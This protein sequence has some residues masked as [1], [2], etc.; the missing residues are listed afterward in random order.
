MNK[1]SVISRIRSGKPTIGSWLTIGHSAVAE[2]LAQAG[3]DW[4]GID[5]EHTTVDWSDMQSMMQAMDACGV[6]PLVRVTSNNPDSIKRAMDAGAAGVIVP[7]VNSTEDARR[8]VASVKYPPL[9]KR[10]VGLARANDYG[11]AFDQYKKEN[12]KNSLVIIQIEHVD[13]LDEI[14]E[15]FSVPGVDAYMVGPYDLSGS[16]GHP[17]EFSHPLMKKA[18]T[19]IRQAGKKMKVPAGFHIVHPDPKAVS[20]RLREGFSFIAYGV[21]M[22]FLATSARDGLKQIKKSVK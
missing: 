18:L 13:A 2:I 22:I 6:V 9:G 21:D 10:G 19:Q 3:F 20:Q 14:E 1:K 11:M 12:N 5:M 16:L 17:G 7:M 4:L 15:I 8:A